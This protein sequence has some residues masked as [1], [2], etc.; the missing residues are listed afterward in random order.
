[1]LSYRQLP[2]FRWRQGARA[3]YLFVHPSLNNQHQSITLLPLPIAL[4]RA[5]APFVTEEGC[6]P[7]WA[8]ERLLGTGWG[9]GGWDGNGHAWTFLAPIKR[10]E[11]IWSWR[12]IDASGGSVARG[13]TRPVRNDRS[14]WKLGRDWFRNVDGKMIDYPDRGRTNIT[15]KLHCTDLRLFLRRA[16]T[17][18]ESQEYLERDATEVIRPSTGCY[19]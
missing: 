12:Q 8:S 16:L 14:A 18:L 5:T 3:V 19:F 11:H 10:R 1:M 15:W 17:L 9:D 2:N 4:S 13:W 7:K 6:I